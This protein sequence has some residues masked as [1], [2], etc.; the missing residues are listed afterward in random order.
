MAAALQRRKEEEDRDRARFMPRNAR[1]RAALA[2]ARWAVET[3]LDKSGHAG[4][5]NGEE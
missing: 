3:H 5:D 4:V 1:R 2:A